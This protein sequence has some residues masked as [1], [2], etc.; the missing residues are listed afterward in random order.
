[1]HK[2][3]GDDLLLVE[4]V[5]Q[6]AVLTLN[7]PVKLNPLSPPMQRALRA[8]V[9]GLRNDRSIR[10]VVMT[11]SGRAFSAGA[12]LTRVSDLDPSQQGVSLGQQR[13]R[14][15]EEVAN[16]MILAVHELNVPI[17]CAANGVVAG[18]GIG[19]ALAADVVVAARSAYFYLPF[20]TG[21]GIIPDLG[22]T[23]FLQRA[24][25]RSRAMA[26]TLLGDRLPAEKAA[27]IGLIYECVDDTELMS[28]A[29]EIAQKLARLPR[30]AAVEVRRTHDSAHA[31]NLRGQLAYEALRQGVLIDKPSFAEGLRAFLEKRPP[32]FD[33]MG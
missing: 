13:S 11:G 33:A 22:T 7:D 12:D 21:L 32:L 26:L 15:M 3:V 6:V 29:L 8:A 20:M 30:H 1:M 2:E 16:P 14:S 25:G 23:W 31:N 19:L 5:G 4:H 17:V 24:I 9:D 27:Q 18:G 10:A 28:R